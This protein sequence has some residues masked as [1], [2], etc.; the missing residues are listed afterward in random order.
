MKHP[1][2]FISCNR[3]WFRH[4]PGDP[5]PVAEK[6]LRTLLRNESDG[7]SRYIDV[8]K[9]SERCLWNSLIGW[10]YSDPDL[11][12][13]F[14]FLPPE[15]QQLW[16]RNTDQPLSNGLL[17]AFAWSHATEGTD[18][19]VQVDRAIITKDPSK[20]PPLPSV[21]AVEPIML[22]GPAD[23][24]AELK[25]AHA[26][27]KTI[28]VLSYGS[29]EWKDILNPLWDGDPERYRIKPEPAPSQNDCRDESFS[30]TVAAILSSG[31]NSNPTEPQ[32]QP[33]MN[34][35]IPQVGETYITNHPR[36]KYETVIASS[37]D[38]VVTNEKGHI[39]HR[40]A[41]EWDGAKPVRYFTKKE[42]RSQ[43]P[44]TQSVHPLSIRRRL[45]R[46]I[47]IYTLGVLTAP[48][49]INYTSKAAAFVMYHIAQVLEK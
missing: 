9:N 43:R 31:G 46:A 21:R 28:Q 25:V 44:V 38:A 35:P 6:Q 33:T 32:T 48:V 39:I 4:K 29:F 14:R 5:C 16:V 22:S 8:I 2:T 41:Q 1:E 37:G 13:D 10:F 17:D 42:L 45:T 12:E 34:T 27:G 15:Y 18:F 47:A 23:P 7:S 20:L 49:A 30:A 24:C 3:P 26:A 40:T 36:S 11:S 19:W